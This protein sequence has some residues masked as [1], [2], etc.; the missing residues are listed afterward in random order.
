M[1]K[2]AVIASLSVN[3]IAN[4]MVFNNELKKSHK[5]AKGWG[6]ETRAVVGSVAK[7]F[8]AMGTTV[9]IGMTAI[10]KENAKVI[11]ELGKMS[12][13]LNFATDKLAGFHMVTELNGES[14]ESFDR[15]IEKMV[16]SLG[17]CPL[18]Q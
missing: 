11:D 9:A 4:S 15:S 14:A 3:L 17:E 8:V 16:R 1:S 7:A 2:N 18:P 6:K 12:D 10:Y 5:K 13:R